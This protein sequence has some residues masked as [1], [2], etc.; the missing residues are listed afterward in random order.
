MKKLFIVSVLVLNL[1]FLRSNTGAGIPPTVT[2]YTSIE[3]MSQGIKYLGS[4]QIVPRN[5]PFSKEDYLISYQITSDSRF[6]QKRSGYLEID[7]SVVP[8]TENVFDRFE[9]NFNV[10]NKEPVFTHHVNSKTDYG[11]Y[12]LLQSKNKNDRVSLYYLT[13]NEIDE[14]SYLGILNSI[15]EALNGRIEVESK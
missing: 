13:E 8:K 7:I 10:N 2:Y 15:V 11:Y 5:L 4:N 1:F 12:I 6:N 9:L 14:S 3:E